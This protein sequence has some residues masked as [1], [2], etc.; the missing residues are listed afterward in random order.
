MKSDQALPRYPQLNAIRDDLNRLKLLWIACCASPLIYLFAAS[1]IGESYF[2]AEKHG[3]GNL[4]AEAFRR[5]LIGFA[6]AG[7]AVQCLMLYFRHSFQALLRAHAGDLG[8]LLRLYTRRTY[9]MIAASECAIVLGFVL[10][11]IQ[12]RLDVLFGFCILGMVYY[13]QS[14]P[15]ESGLGALTQSR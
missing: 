9:L 12:G 13:A 8:E 4:S 3:F 7:A 5:I 2:N 10:F 11:L 6:A 1:L 15:S 14:Y